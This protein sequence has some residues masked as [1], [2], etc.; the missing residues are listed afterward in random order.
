MSGERAYVRVEGDVRGQLVVGD[1]NVVVTAEHSVVTVLQP[2]ERP[3][4]VRRE[5][6]AL[7]P[8]R[9]VM[10]RGRDRELA[11]IDQAVAAAEPL[12]VHGVEGM[13]KS[14]L[15][16]HAA[17]QMDGADAGVVFLNTAGRDVGDI[18][19]DVFEACYDSE[20]YR[21]SAV[22]LR[23][24]MT[25]VDVRVV[26]DD[27]ECPGPELTLLLDLL[28]DAAMVIASSTRSLW[29]RGRML[30][31]GG[32][33][34]QDG[35]ALL[36]DLLERPLMPAEATAA[37]ALWEVTRGNPLQLVR[38][39]AA[40]RPGPD[41]QVVLPR[42]GEV[43]SLVPV[44]L[45]RLSPVER[46]TVSLLSAAGTPVSV[47]LLA[48]LLGAEDFA[49]TPG[50]LGALGL[51]SLSEHGCR[52]TDGV[53][54]ALPA[55][56]TPGPERL[57][58]LAGRLREW[59][60]AAGRSPMDV[61]DH[62]RLV[63]AVIEAATLAGQSDAA[64]RLAAAASPGVAR[65]LRWASWENILARGKAAAEAA[66]DRRLVAYFTHEDGIRSLLTGKRVAAAAALGAAAAIWADLGAKGP[67]TVAQQ[68]Q[69]LCA[70]GAA[71][72]P[73]VPDP[74]SAATAASTPATSGAASAVTA[75][76]VAAA[77]L[78]VT[79]AAAAG[80]V[81]AYNHYVRTPHRA[82]APA[83]QLSH[84]NSLGCA[85]AGST[86][87]TWSQSTPRAE[88]QVVNNGSRPVTVYWLNYTGGRE[89]WADVAPGS[90]RSFPT[91]LTHPWLMTSSSGRC[92]AVFLPTSTLGRVTVSG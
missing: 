1:H 69:G 53:T 40:A 68:A 74:G 3:R 75:K 19:Q 43:A 31:L 86:K 26:L 27:V 66:G 28:P 65:S 71:P 52:L 5:R 6:V 14:T 46:E 18:A 9:T 16:R 11:D 21:P 22:E 91:F 49:G 47:E 64:A 33:D 59:V 38:A 13:G 12:Q 48:F 84:L 39:A 73:V 77:G 57:A 60:A 30:P 72:P 34:R 78:A 90:R 29:G 79:A 55:E 61:A 80:G 70:P 82:S 87:A 50:H 7:L 62:G 2:G 45:S 20:G 24:L 76:V 17:R 92:L 8:R 67:A 88:F 56:L 15:I 10:L 83:V 51:T 4:P 85:R 37:D 32:L 54:A 41:G 23:R 81:T 63:T 58:G 35:Q 44:L 25:G 89:R 36:A 42:P